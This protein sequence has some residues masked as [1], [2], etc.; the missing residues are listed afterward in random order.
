VLVRR[1][2][3]GA[4][5]CA[6]GIG[7]ALWPAAPAQADGSLT[8]N[9]DN[10]RPGQSIGITTAGCNDKDGT[11]T[12]SSGAFNRVSTEV[13]S[14]DVNT[15]VTI[16]RNAR[17]GTTYKVT[18]ICQTSH[19]LLY[20]QITIKRGSKPH[21]PRCWRDL[22][23]HWHGNCHHR[24]PDTGGGGS[25]DDGAQSTALGLGLLGTGAAVGGFTWFRRVRA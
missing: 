6:G 9:P 8:I 24:G 17:V 14:G 15:S 3:I 22:H 16:R 18:M 20:G 12:I 21:H 25:L 5:V 23:G 11:A 10:A 19:I 4:L 7:M 2:T 13:S 1:T